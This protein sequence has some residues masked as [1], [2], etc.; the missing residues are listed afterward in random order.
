MTEIDLNRS[1]HLV[2]P[3]LAIWG[4]EIPV[5]LFLGGVTA[6]IMIFTAVLALRRSGAG[7]RWA[8]WLP[9]AAPVLLSL[10][11]LA[12]LL[13]LEYKT[14]AYRFYL[15]FRPTSPMSWGAWILVAIYP[16]TIALGIAR[17]TPAEVEAV[18]G[19]GPARRLGI[20]RLLRWAH[21]YSVARSAT[22][23]ALSIALG[24]ALGAYTGVLIGSLGARAAW[25]SP[26]LAPL[27]LVSGVS[28]GAAFMLLFPLHDDEQHLLKRTDILVIVAELAL[29]ALY[30]VG[31]VTTGGAA[32]ADAAALFVSGRFTAAF[33]LLVVMAGLVVPLLMSFAEHARH[34]PPTRVVP[35]LVLVGG[36]SLRWILIA[37]GQA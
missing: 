34:V 23:A 35:V 1:N 27:F 28:T 33:W 7:S 37:A 6:G 5:Y 12:L 26:L 4:W 22:L 16:V 32:G 13:D 9:F 18:A 3:V 2:D 36:L 29:L 19:T 14:H 24:I 20:S 15:T 21:A 11:M 30:L 25:G 10:G 31:L 17:L 8:R